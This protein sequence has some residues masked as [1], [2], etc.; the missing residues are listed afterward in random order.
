MCVFVCVCVVVSILRQR[1]LDIFG[2]L[3]DYLGST[4]ARHFIIL[5][6]IVKQSLNS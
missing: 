3:A 4:L 1:S 2:M 6:Y 5:Y